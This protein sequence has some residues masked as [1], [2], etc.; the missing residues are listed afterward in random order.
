MW[1]CPECERKFKSTNQD[2][3]C[4]KIE[5]ID[6]YI[7]EQ[8]DEIQ[9][10]L[11]KLREVIRSAAPNATEKM[12]WQMP[13]FW[14]GENLIHFAAFKKHI[15]I[16]PGAEAATVFT[17]RLIEYKVAKG[18]IQLPLHKPLP[19][20][21]IADIARWRVSC[22]EGKNNQDM[23]A[24]KMTRKVY[25]IPDYLA[26]AL[27]GSGLRERYRARPPYQR[28][29]YIGWI[30]RGKREETRRKRLNQMLDELRSG[31]AYM[32]MEY[33]AR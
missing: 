13:T 16:F 31:D 33:N 22:V 2:H 8:A 3:C 25:D 1:Q 17:D 5:T 12:A 11:Y 9:P 28:N 24:S 4:G 21:L 6:R 19:Y 30:T 18:T 32:G 23:D 26:A 27:D 29:D 7:S 15:S 10:L 20:E 14:Q